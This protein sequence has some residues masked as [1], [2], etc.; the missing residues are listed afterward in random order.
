MTTDQSATGESVHSRGLDN[1]ALVDRFSLVIGGPFYDMLRRMKL[2]EPAP[3]V[4][5]RIAVL[6]LLTWVPLG[7]LSGLQGVLFGKIVRLPLLYDFSIYG[8]FFLGLPLLIIAEIVI[9]PWTRR[10]VET[11][12]K[13]GIIPSAEIP[14]YHSILGKIMRLRNSALAEFVVFLVSSLPLYILDDREWVSRGLTTWHGT[15]SGGFTAA[16]WWFVFISSP[17]VRFLL[18]RWLWR[19]CLW[20]LLLFRVMKL[21]LNLMPTHP[22]L[23]GGLGFVL[24]AQRQ[25]GILF[26]AL[27][28]FLA[29]QYGNSIAYFAV[30]LSTT[31]VPMAVFVV[32]AVILVLCPMLFLTPKLIELQREGL[33]RYSQ[34]ARNLTEAFDAK[35]TR[36]AYTSGE[37]MLGNPDPSS[38]ID[39]V[40]SYQVVRDLKV[41]P[42]NKQLVLQVAAQAGSPLALVWIV[43]TPLENIIA[44]ILKMMV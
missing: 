35:W 41:V 9:D 22:D 30:P 12:D 14:K 28:G 23:L 25:F 38:L 37:S 44:G 18:L 4:R 29:G 1:P 32:M 42:I 31:K 6:I 20:G 40:G 34:V 13:S 3:N 43:A 11:F 7:I 26:A 24:N 39:Y 2:V 36:D 33:S 15:L 5:G 19:Y 21:D 16:G 8:R 17:I 10:V 27:G